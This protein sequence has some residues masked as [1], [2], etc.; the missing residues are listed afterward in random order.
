M[1]L[2]LSK[3]DYSELRDAIIEDAI[4]FSEVPNYL[5]KIRGKEEGAGS[6]KYISFKFRMLPTRKSP[7]LTNPNLK[8]LAKDFLVEY[9]TLVDESHGKRLSEEKLQQAFQNICGTLTSPSEAQKAD[10][11]VAPPI[12]T[13]ELVDDVALTT[14]NK[15]PVVEDLFSDD[16][17]ETAV[18]PTPSTSKQAVDLSSLLDDTDLI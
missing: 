18:I 3:S 5:I 13:D 9:R 15:P 7:I 16:L 17:V 1:R 14:P 2:D 10:D 11:N 12:F 6:F 8:A 4:E